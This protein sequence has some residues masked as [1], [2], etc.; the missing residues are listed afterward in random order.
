MVNR[1]EFLAVSAGMTAAA[2]GALEDPAAGARSISSAKATTMRQNQMGQSEFAGVPVGNSAVLHKIAIE[3]I[4]ASNLVRSGVMKRRNGGSYGDG[5]YPYL[6]GLPT[7]AYVSGPNYLVQGDD[8][9]HL[10]KLDEVLIHRQTAFV[11]RVLSRML[12]LP[13][14]T[15]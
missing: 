7:I 6:V 3:E 11:A 5:T 14:A 8:G 12:D 10:D 4:Q 15:L 9:D 1:R 13:S 2:I